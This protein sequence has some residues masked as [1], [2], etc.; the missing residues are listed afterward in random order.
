MRCLLS[1][2]NESREDL[3]TGFVTSNHNVSNRTCDVLN[4]TSDVVNS[5]SK[6]SNAKKS[7]RDSIPQWY[8]SIRR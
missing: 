2:G 1:R 7:S 3:F 6:V 4:P 8:D 5:T